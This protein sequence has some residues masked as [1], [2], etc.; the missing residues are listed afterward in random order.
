[1]KT[2]A[3]YILAAPA[4]AL[5]VYILIGQID[6]AAIICAVVL[7]INLLLYTINKRIHAVNGQLSPFVLWFTGL[8]CSGKSTLAN[9]T[10][11]YLKEK[12]YRV[13]QL[14]GDTVRSILPETGFT[15][16]ARNNHIKR[17]GYLT[18]VLEKNGIIVIASFVS[19]YRESRNF[20]REIC[21]SFVEVFVDA[22]VEECEKRDVKGLYKR[23]RSGE[24]INFTGIS[25]PYEAPE[26][27]ELTVNTDR[28]NKKESFDKIKKIIKPFIQNQKQQS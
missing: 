27:P 5:L 7:L 9:M 21:N 6:I 2:I 24:I 1:M 23:A 3:W 15:R 17:V 16:D 4:T 25:D 11:H 10:Y 22:S 20:V 28:E 18:S 8:P 13:E 12:K 26:D 14:D 19:P